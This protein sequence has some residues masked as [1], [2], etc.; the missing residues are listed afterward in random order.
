MILAMHLGSP[1]AAEPSVEQ[2]VEIKELLA[3][4]DVAA[5]R[6]YLERYPELLEGDAQLAVLLRKFLLESKHLPNYLLSDTRDS[7]EDERTAESPRAGGA[8]RGPRDDPDDS[9]DGV[10]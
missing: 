4:N 10:Y 1:A 6:T 7:G 9:D 8:G 5:L 2:L 3:Q